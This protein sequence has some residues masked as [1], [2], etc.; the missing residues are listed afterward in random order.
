M[1]SALSILLKLA[2]AVIII[3][4]NIYLCYE[5]YLN[6]YAPNK[7]KPTIYIIDATARTVLTT[8][9]VTSMANFNGTS[10]KNF[11]EPLKDFTEDIETKRKRRIIS[12]LYVFLVLIVTIHNCFLKIFLYGWNYYKYD[13]MHDIAF[14][15]FSFTLYSYVQVLDGISSRLVV[16]RHNLNHLG[17]DMIS[18]VLRKEIV[19]STH[20][21]GMR[22]NMLCKGI[23]EINRNFGAILIT[24]IVY[25]IVSK[26]FCIVITVDYIINRAIIESKYSY[27]IQ[28]VMV[29]ITVFVIIV[30][31]KHALLN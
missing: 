9:I 16:L 12:L 30:V 21:I 22:F 18:D 28:A 11:I 25:L 27:F 23:E 26:L 13:W 15:I 2:F 5:L 24:S 8:C 29:F 6:I 20:C 31:I 14:L 10:I 3:L 4:S 7:V 1:Y 19:K 17:K